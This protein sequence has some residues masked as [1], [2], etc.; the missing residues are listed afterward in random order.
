MAGS[1]AQHEEAFARLSAELRA[2]GVVPTGAP[3]GRYFNDPRQVPESELRWELGVPV[4]SHV[5]ARA[6]FEVKDL[7]GGETAIL[8]HEG[9]YAS[10]TSAWP[11]LLEWV[12]SHGY[13]PVGPAMQIYLGN[14]QLSGAQGP[15]TELRLP[16]AKRE[17]PVSDTGPLP[18]F[19]SPWAASENLRIVVH[20]PNGPDR[21]LTDGR[22]DFKP[23]W[24]PDGTMLTFFRLVTRG[25]EFKDWRT[26]ICVIKVDGTGLR[27]L[28]SGAHAD[29]NPTWTRDGTQRIVFNRYSP[30]GGWHNRAYWISPNAAPGEEQLVSDPSYPHF[31]WVTG[32][33]RDGRL[34]VDRVTPTSVDSYL[35][36]PDPGRAGHYE[37]LKRPTTQVWHKLTVSPSERRV[38]Y[39]LD[40]DRNS[41]TYEDVVLCY[42][43]LDLATRAIANQVE[44]TE[45]RAGVV[46]E[47][48]AWSHD[49]TLVYYDS[50]VLGRYQLF[51][52][53]IADATTRRVSPH[54]DRDYQFVALEG[55]PR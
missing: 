27:E 26:R 4:D 49:E 22:R 25:P 6:P 38:A 7:P 50:N 55:L 16:V 44:I 1:H 28:T 54:S 8:V 21:V 45:T 33:L 10:S 30:Q 23:S 48:P 31:E 29:F 36:R 53:R 12:V 3:F 15:R 34:L 43:D 40:R 42:A 13:R 9:E 24:S 18:L 5:K 47:Y 51:A 41:A 20:A 14:P 35:L 46:H 11:V 32:A 19:D 17:G 37:H 52:Y 39:M 2:L